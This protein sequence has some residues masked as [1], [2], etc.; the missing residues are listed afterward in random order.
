MYL[1]NAIN[2]DEQKVNK[3][4]G[5]AIQKFTNWIDSIS[6]QLQNSIELIYDRVQSLQ[7]SDRRKYNNINERIIKYLIN[8]FMLLN[9]LQNRQ[10]LN[11]IL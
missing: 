8:I 3:L 1:L 11:K 5:K 6:H 10:K 2:S 9:G 4:K 7:G